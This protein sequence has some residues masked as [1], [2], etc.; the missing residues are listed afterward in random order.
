MYK[1]MYHI[2]FNGITDVLEMLETGNVWDAK[3]A[4]MEAQCQAEEVYIS[5]NGS[6]EDKEDG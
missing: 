1:K 4:L 2:L 5:W 6:E 3:K